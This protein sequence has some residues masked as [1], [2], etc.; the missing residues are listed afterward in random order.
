MLVVVAV[1]SRQNL[2]VDRRRQALVAAAA[3][4]GV[5]TG[6]AVAAFQWITEDLTL[7][8]LFAAPLAVQVIAPAIGL[9]VAALSLRF[10][11]RSSSPA[12][13]DE[14][15]ADFHSPDRHL[16]LRHVPGRIIASIA[17]L[18]SGGAMGFEGPAIYL[19]AG[20]G[21]KVQQ[22]LSRWFRRE[23]AKALLVAGAAGGVAAIF[24]APATGVLFALEVPYQDDIS[25]R[26]LIP[27]LVA[28]ATSYLTFATL[29]GTE[30]L[31]ALPR[32]GPHRAIALHELAGALALGLLAGLGARAF[33]K[34]MTYAKH[35]AA[36]SRPVVRVLV[37]GGCL[38]A[39]AFASHHLFGEALTIGPGYRTIAWMAEPD[40][41]LW[42]LAGLFLL[43]LAATGLTVGGGGAGGMFIPLVI[44]GSILG[45][46]VAG[47]FDGLGLNPP[48]TSEAA[49]SFFPILGIAAFLGA[50]YRTPLAAVMFVAE[51]TGK[52]EFVVPAL[53]AAALSQ[54]LMGGDSVS[55]VQHGRRAGHLERRIRL[56]IATALSTDVR[57]V[58]SDATLS[59]FVW[60]HAIGN[61]QRSVPVVDGGAYL[62]MCHLEDVTKRD[63]EGWETTVVG[64]VLRADDPVG[65]MSWTLRDALTA[66]EAADVDRLA[67]VDSDGYF[68]GEVVAAEIMRL[69]EILEDTAG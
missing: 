9:A 59:E 12:T 25:R 16:L 27:G 23:D 26:G 66:M 3:V 36:E 11:G 62:G 65:D 19:G 69:S 7:H 17:T 14:Y 64:D 39:L 47:S 15:V 48:G 57:T 46:F 45:R 41:G 56:P 63:R 34:L 32:Q 13:A 37:A 53:I 44:Q 33:A 49:S 52:A 22:K 68:V 5:F 20:I 30:P 38:G 8:R 1:R 6:V 4:T 24:R 50:G 51:T 67:V 43:R 31:L 60:I 10:L 54:L 28:G 21:S 55:T 58:P 29:I 61:R 35:V 2:L 40:R 42:L 18:G